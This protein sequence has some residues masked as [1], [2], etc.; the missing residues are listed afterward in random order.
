MGVLVANLPLS[1]SGNNMNPGGKDSLWRRALWTHQLKPDLSTLSD[2]TPPPFNFLPRLGKNVNPS[3]GKGSSAFSAKTLSQS[4][5][6]F[7]RVISPIPPVSAKVH[8]VPALS[9]FT[10][11]LTT[12]LRSHKYQLLEPTTDR[13]GNTLIFRQR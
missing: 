10:E 13:V 12:N 7:F 6:G 11:T 1:V 4:G 2:L 3:W 5:K 9:T 8:E